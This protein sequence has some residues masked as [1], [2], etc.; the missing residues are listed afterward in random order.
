[1]KK[2]FLKVMGIALALT[3]VLLSVFTGCAPK[4]E[5]EE[6]AA[7]KKV[8]KKEIPEEQDEKSA[9]KASRKTSTL[10]IISRAEDDIDQVEFSTQTI[11]VNEALRAF[12]EMYNKGGK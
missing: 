6:K 10:D 4:T 11:D 2:T 12:D 7:G 5:P 9:A 3:L 8:Y 1:M